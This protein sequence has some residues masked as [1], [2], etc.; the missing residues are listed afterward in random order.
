MSR[1]NKLAITSE[2][3]ATYKKLANDEVL[4]STIP[5][6]EDFIVLARKDNAIRVLD[7]ACGDGKNLAEMIRIPEFF[8]VG[9]DNSPTALK[10]CQREVIM[11]N[12]RFIEYGLLNIKRLHNFC[13]V[14]C[15]LEDMP[16][17]DDHFDAAICIDVINHNREPYKIFDELK[18]VVKMNG[19]LY[20]S[21]FNIND[22][23]IRSYKHEMVEVSGGVDGRE[24]IYSHKNSNGDHIDYYFRFL[25]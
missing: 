15:Q 4:W 12:K 21:L 9:C 10:L 3:D 2:W 14:E 22:E 7:A 5:E 19:L 25:H 6:I 11:R 1:K 17:P 8:C 23:I 20:F 16:F 13:L 18:R 24:F